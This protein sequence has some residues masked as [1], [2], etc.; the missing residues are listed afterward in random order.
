MT[1]PVKKAGSPGGPPFSFDC[2]SIYAE[3][4][5]ARRQGLGF[6]DVACTG[7]GKPATLRQG[8]G[9]AAKVLSAFRESGTPAAA[10]A[11]FSSGYPRRAAAAN[12]AADNYEV[13]IFRHFFVAGRGI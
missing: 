4:S 6:D 1:V 7:V 12:F 5:C 2:F 10:G 13:P 11:A 3:E 9:V 8:R